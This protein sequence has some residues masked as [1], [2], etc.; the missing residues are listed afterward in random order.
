M[1]TIFLTFPEVLYS[2]RSSLLTHRFQE[3]A[4]ALI[5]LHARLF[6]WPAREGSSSKKSTEMEKGGGGGEGKDTEQYFFPWG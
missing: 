3:E 2:L 4:D 6:V 5:D 1:I